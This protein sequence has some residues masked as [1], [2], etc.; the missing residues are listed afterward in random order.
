MNLLQKHIWL[1]ETIRRAGKITH[2]E[3]SDRWER[4]KSLSDGM[5]LQRSTF[6]RWR[7]AI[8]SQFGIDI[9]CQRTGGYLYYIE[10][11]E[12]IDDDKLKKWMLDSFAVGN[13]I[14]ENLSLKGR[15]LVDEIPSGREY[16]TTILEAMKESRVV[17]I[18]YHPFK[19][20]NHFTFPLE[21]YCVKLFENRWY[22]LAHNIR[23]GDIRCY[24]LDRIESAELTGESFKLPK[25]FSAENYFSTFY[26]IVTGDRTKPVRIVIRANETHKHYLKTLP[27]HHSQRLIE[28][29]GKCADFE[30]YLAPTYDFIMKLFQI[31]PMIE[32]ISPHAL[33]EELKARISEMQAI[34]GDAPFN[35]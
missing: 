24:S 14:G 30:L 19:K 22:V 35:L 16:L 9:S 20:A 13:I 28:D 8:F 27:L 6:N 32:V 2:K 10:N 34:Y 15:I 12:E 7:E 5:P 29:T 23:Y 1:I 4:N 26:G 3:L 25:D 18:T 21:P 17:N 33:R 11:P 31:G